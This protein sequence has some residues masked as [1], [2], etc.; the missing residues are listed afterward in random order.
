MAAPI[1]A[2]DLQALGASGSPD[3]LDAL[4]RQVWGLVLAAQPRLGGPD[5]APIVSAALRGVLCAICLRLHDQGQG[6]TQRTQ[7]APGFSASQSFTPG[8]TTFSTLLLPSEKQELAALVAAIDGT[9]TQRLAFKVDTATGWS[10]HPR[11][12]SLWSGSAYC[13]CGAVLAW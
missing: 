7:T 5:L 9:P 3:R 1:T 11:T 2:A 6:L 8:P 4:I 10:P 12:C 13:S